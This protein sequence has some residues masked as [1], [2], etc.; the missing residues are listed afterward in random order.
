R[1]GNGSCILE[2]KSVWTIDGVARDLL[3]WFSTS[4]ANL[5]AFDRR[6]A[7]PACTE[8]CALETEIPM[9]GRFALPS[10]LLAA[11]AP[12]AADAP[13][14]SAADTSY[15]VQDLGSLEG[16]M[17]FAT[18]VNASG[19][20][21]GYS[22]VAT[23]FGSVPHA[24]LW[25]AGAMRDLGTPEDG[26]YSVATGINASGQVV[27]YSVFPRFRALVFDERGITDL[28]TLGGAEAIG[29]GINDEGE[30]VGWST[31]AYTG[32]DH[33]FHYRDGAMTDLGTVDGFQSVATGINA[34]GQIA[35]F[36]VTYNGHHA[37]LYESGAFTALGDLGYPFG[38]TTGINAS[39]QV[40]GFSVTPDLLSHAFRYQSGAPMADLGTLGGY[41]SFGES[42]NAAGD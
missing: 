19:Q 30:V 16:S 31:P 15:V 17:T 35:L 20:V 14:A 37:F 26:N 41:S 7:I 12:P 29:H 5:V 4:Q 22:Y 10:L 32:L 13:L 36:T 11:L 21:T 33:A 6:R 39:G 38:Q 27:G 1:C 25:S 28:G 3:R 8:R 40:T 23:S 24:F 9:I 34:S 18:G 42:I 2:N